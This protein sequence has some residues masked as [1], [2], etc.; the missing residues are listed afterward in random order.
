MADGGAGAAGADEHD[1]VGRRARQ[2]ARERLPEAARVG[3]VPDE[4]V[5]REDDRVDRLQ[6]LRLGGQLVELADD[7]LLA[8]MRDVQAA[9]ARVAR[10]ADER[11]DLGGIAA[12]LVEVEQPVGV[13]EPEARRLALVQRRAQRVADAGADQPDRVPLTSLRTSSPSDAMY[14]LVR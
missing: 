2:A 1:V 9:Q 11:A 12:E 7:E 13:V 14:E 4:A 3:V 10:L 6:R 8:G 5:A